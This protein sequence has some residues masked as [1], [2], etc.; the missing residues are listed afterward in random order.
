MDSRLLS[1]DGEIF[2]IFLLFVD[3]IPIFLLILALEDASILIKPLMNPLSMPKTL[4]FLP[5]RLALLLF[6]ALWAAN[7][8]ASSARMEKPAF[9]ARYERLSTPQ[10]MA[11]AMKRVCL[12]C[13]IRCR[14]PQHSRCPWK[15]HTNRF[16]PQ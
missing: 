12:R 4:S 1:S 2:Q 15:D 11:K 13:H 6:A 5:Q 9:Y 16:Y 7:L 10:M 3:K 8:A 14:P